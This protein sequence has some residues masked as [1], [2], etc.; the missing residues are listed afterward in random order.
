MIWRVLC[1]VALLGACRGEAAELTLFNPA[2]TISRTLAVEVARTEAERAKG[3]MFRTAL[4]DMCGMVFMFA[5][6]D[7]HSFWMKNTL[8]PLDMLFIRKGKVVDV[9]PNAR[10]LDLTAITPDE[11]ADAVLEVNGGWVARFG[12]GVGWTLSPSAVK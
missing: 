1:V 4:C 3:L 5:E 2:R 6:P 8:I 11:P 9:H 12:V 10:P 7:Y